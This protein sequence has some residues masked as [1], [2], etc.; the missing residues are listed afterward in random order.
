MVREEEAGKLHTPHFNSE[1]LR[2]GHW[3][4]KTISNQIYWATLGA[5]IIFG[6]PMLPSAWVVRQI[7]KTDGNQKTKDNVYKMQR[8]IRNF[9]L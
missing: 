3:T 2:A 5:G 8:L 9:Y 6:L 4:Q 1:Y 7:R